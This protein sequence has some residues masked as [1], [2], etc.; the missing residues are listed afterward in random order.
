MWSPE[1]ALVHT[2][3]LAAGKPCVL[4]TLVLACKNRLTETEEVNS[5]PYDVLFIYLF[6]LRQHLDLELWPARY[7]L[8][9]LG[10]P[11]A[12][13]VLTLASA[14]IIV[15]YHRTQ[16]TQATLLETSV[17]RSVPQ[18]V[19]RQVSPYPK[20]GRGAYMPS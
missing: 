16:L 7:S 5:V 10:W 4:E 9:S 14:G 18:T 8:C 20:A 15:W 17:S 19:E 3:Q 6:V 1:V 12:C 2:T 13:G 11:Q